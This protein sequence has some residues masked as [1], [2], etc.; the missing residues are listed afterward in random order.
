MIFKP[1]ECDFGVTVNGQNYDFPHVVSFAVEDPE[2][3]NLVRGSNAGNKSGLVFK[4]GI[5]DPKTVTATIIGMDATIYGVLKGAYDAQTRV[6][7][8]CVN[9]VDGSSKIAKNAVLSQEPKQLNVDDSAESMNVALA[10]K[11]F[12]VSETHKS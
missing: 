3:T 8:Y 11:S 10:F 12:D 5:K 6:D 9:R 2:T 7:C 1:Y 4:E